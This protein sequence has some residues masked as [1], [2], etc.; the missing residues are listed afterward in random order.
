MSDIP[1]SVNDMNY[2]LMHELTHYERGDIFY[3]WFAMTIQSIHWFNPFVYIVLREIVTECEVNAV[4]PIENQMPENVEKKFNQSEK[5]AI[6]D[7]FYKA[8][9]EYANRI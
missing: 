1:F 2:I 4:I 6:C 9:Y 8:L 7:G 5:S 3:K